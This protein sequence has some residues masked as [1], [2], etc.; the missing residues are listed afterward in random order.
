[1]DFFIV[2]LPHLILGA[3]FLHHYSP[4]VDVSKQRLVNATISLSTPACKSIATIVSPSFFVVAAGNQFHA[5][6]S[7][8]ELTDLSFKTYPGSPL[9]SAFPYND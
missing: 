7:F 9:D 8:P 5:L 4:I 6:T 3:D 2:D 1:M